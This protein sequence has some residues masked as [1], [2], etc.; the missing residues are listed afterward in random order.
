MDTPDMDTTENAEQPQSPQP[1]MT[2]ELAQAKAQAEEYLAGW[3]RAMA[4]YANLKREADRAQGELAKY[5]AAGLVTQL[6]PLLDSFKKAEAT[7]PT[8][9]SGLKP[10]VDGINAIGGQFE[11][12]LKSAGVSRIEEAEVPFDPSRHEAM[13][14]EKHSRLKPGLVI[15]VLEPGYTMHERVLRPAKVVVAE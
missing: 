5:A 8:D 2:D 15:K 9:L 3:K 11:A 14:A 10:W 1:A 7:L 6:L 4:D 13:L 12:V